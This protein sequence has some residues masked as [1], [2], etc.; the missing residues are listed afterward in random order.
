V[1]VCLNKKYWSAN[2]DKLD[3]VLPKK[4]AVIMIGFRNKR[5][6]LAMSAKNLRKWCSPTAPGK[7]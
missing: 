3:I 7:R 5:F 4:E 1:E 2:P 6:T